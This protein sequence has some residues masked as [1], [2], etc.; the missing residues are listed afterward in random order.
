MLIQA[1]A[2]VGRAAFTQSSGFLWIDDVEIR[3]LLR[4]RRPA[5][6]LFLDP[7]PPG[8]LLVAPD[9][10]ADRLVRRCRSLGVE[11]ETENGVFRAAPRSNTT[12]PP[13]AVAA[14]GGTPAE[15]TRIPAAARP[16]NK[17]PLPSRR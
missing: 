7:S 4:T 12:P 13:A 16:R 2:V 8:G 17:T 11:V 9:V 3:E 15:G 10:D 5:A 14:K 6:E 1:S